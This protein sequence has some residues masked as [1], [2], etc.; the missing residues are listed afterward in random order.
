MKIAIIGAGGMAEYHYKGFTEAGAEVVAIV[1]KSEDRAKAFASAHGIDTVCSSISEALEKIKIDAVSIATPNRFHVPLATEA[2]N[3]GLSVFCEKPPALN[4]KE[5]EELCAVAEKSDKILMFDFNN[6]ARPDSEYLKNEIEKGALGDINSVQA[7]WIR[8]AGIP[9]IGG[10]FTNKAISGGGPV[11]DL[12]HML[13]LSLYFMGYKDPEWVLASTFN[14]FMGN[15][16][17]KGP[18]GIA[19]NVNGVT[20]VESASHAFIRFKDGSCLYSRAS[21][22]EM[23]ER[24]HVAV[25]LQGSIAGAS[26]SRIFE[27]DGIDET[28]IDSLDF[29]KVKE[30]KQVNE[31]VNIEQ[32]EAMGRI[33]MASS[34][35]KAIEGKEKAK[36]TPQEALKL[37]KIIDAL[38]LSASTGKPVEIKE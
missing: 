36:S 35:V 24:E 3:L 7:E 26:I 9:G 27:K 15:P 33:K 20:D 21:W 10:W 28:A 37:M 30:H 17:F 23:V 16:D 34:F 8:R 14:D 19:D 25:T 29:Y 38:Y 22:A 32:D 6:R 1:D 2:L 18:W 12:V 13:D 11:I 5:M 4:G 31:K